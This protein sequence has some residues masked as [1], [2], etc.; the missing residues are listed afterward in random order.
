M[1]GMK[2]LSVSP[3]YISLLALLI[4]V[5]AYRV[6]IFR[7]SEKIA[8]GEGNCSKSMK[9]S[10]RAHGNAVENIPIAALL[11]LMLE[12]NSLN[13]L[14]LHAFGLVLVVSRVAHAWGLS[15]RNGL[16]SGRFYGTLFTW[17]LIVLMLF[18]NVLILII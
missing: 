9:S 12:L 14:L 4:I 7:R 6:T 18:L 2:M 3:I 17:L 13:P 16:T 8:L 15:K 1:T 11:L 5:L 10:I